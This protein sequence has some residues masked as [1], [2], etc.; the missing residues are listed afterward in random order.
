ME[1]ETRRPQSRTPEP[2][3]SRS[4]GSRYGPAVGDDIDTLPRRPD[5]MYERDSEYQ[6]PEAQ[7]EQLPE[8]EEFYEEWPEEPEMANSWQDTQ[9]PDADEWTDELEDEEEEQV[10]RLSSEPQSQYD[11]DDDDDA[12]DDDEDD[13]ESDP[14]SEEARNRKAATLGHKETYGDQSWLLREPEQEASPESA[15]HDYPDVVEEEERVDDDDERERDSIYPERDQVETLT[16]ARDV[17]KPKKKNTYERLSLLGL[18]FEQESEDLKRKTGF[19][20]P[21]HYTFGSPLYVIEP[22][23]ESISNSLSQLEAATRGAPYFLSMN[24]PNGASEPS[25][26]VNSVNLMD[27]LLAAVTDNLNNATAKNGQESKEPDSEETG[28]REVSTLKLDPETETSSGNEASNSTDDFKADVADS[29]AAISAS[30]GDG[31]RFAAVTI[32]NVNP[33]AT[34]GSTTTNVTTSINLGG[35]S[36]S[37]NPNATATVTTAI[38]QSTVDSG[39]TTSATNAATTA[40]VNTAN[41]NAPEIP[42]F[43]RQCHRCRPLMPLSVS[44]ETTNGTAN[45]TVPETNVST[46]AMPGSTADETTP[47]P[48]TTAAGTETV[49]DTDSNTTMAPTEPAPSPLV[50]KASNP[51]TQSSQSAEQA[52]TAADDLTEQP[53]NSSP[54]PVTPNDSGQNSS[55]SATTPSPSTASN[56]S[57]V[58][59]A[60][61]TEK[62]TTIA[63]E[64]APVSSPPASKGQAVNKTAPAKP[65]PQ[66]SIEKFHLAMDMNQLKKDDQRALATAKQVNKADGDT[67]AH[68][69]ADEDAHLQTA[70]RQASQLTKPDNREPANGTSG[71]ASAE[72]GRKRIA[73]VRRR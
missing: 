68:S 38:V 22:M 50:D 3:S 63:P 62:G 10:S 31:A 30:I 15:D 18:T 35:L 33:S 24:G 9:S 16:S 34:N 2:D 54:A 39:S 52:T 5:F 20:Y 25:E 70:L 64:S 14:L 49:D 45:A 1:E 53:T 59:L 73:R 23:L 69:N 6:E 11:G 32:I 41:I 60:P 66:V 58:T 46:T 7:E 42:G 4:V 36:G 44:A 56:S 13:D 47:S 8:P 67:V 43:I 55:S 51:T 26:K 21:L 27:K 19:Q 12:D 57:A 40:T 37:A 65:G 29:S 28:S 17:V 71:Q 61:D 48:A 72:N